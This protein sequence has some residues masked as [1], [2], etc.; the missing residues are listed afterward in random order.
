MSEETNE[1]STTDEQQQEQRLYEELKKIR[2][3]QMAAQRERIAAARRAAERQQMIEEMPRRQIAVIA[4]VDAQGGFAKDGKIPWHYP[5]DLRWF[6]MITKDS[7]CL[8]G[9]NTYEDINARLGPKAAESVLPNRRCFVLS[10]SLGSISNATIV[11]G[12]LDCENYMPDDEGDK[13]IFV[14]GGERLFTEGISR[15]NTVYLTVI[16]K[17]FQCDQFFPVRY[18][19]ERFYVDKMYKNEKSPDVRFTI[20]KRKQEV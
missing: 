5:E 4:A 12:V 2:E 10:S 9:K 17:Q 6:K 15:A 1:Q 11:K 16:N 13:T 8:M 14:I 3:A 18:L 7:P 20:W 19:E